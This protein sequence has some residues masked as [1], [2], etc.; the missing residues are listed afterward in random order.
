M[1]GEYVAPSHARVTVGELGPAWLDRQRG[2]LKPSAYRPLEIA[3]RVRVAPR[4]GDVALGDI[5]PTAVQQWVS[6]L[7]RGVDGAKPV[8]ATVVIRTHQVLSAIL[9][10][11]VRDDLLAPN[12]ALASSCP[13]R[14][15]SGHV[16]L[17]HQQVPAGRR[18][19]A[20]TR[21]WCCCWPTPGCDG[22]RRPG[23]GSAISTCCA[24][25]PPSPRTPSRSGRRCSSAPP[26]ATSSAPCRCPSS[27]CPTWPASAR[28]GAATICCSPATTAGICNARTPVGV[29][30]QS[31]RRVRRSAHHAARPSSHRGQPR[32]VG[33]RERQGGPEDARACLGGD[34]AGHLRRPVR[35]RPGGGRDRSARRPRSGKCG[36][37]VGT[38]WRPGS[39]I[40]R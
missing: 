36:Q 30:R 31:G 26:R 24:G 39:A 20:S 9:A 1:R 11:A 28:A 15:A 38:G 10:D 17:T 2:H 13:A 22:A 40:G 27:C 16:Y 6:D 34:D 18:R 5:R 19:R 23:C 32:G 35:R 14:P 33:R 3:W 4:W 21:G 8:G 29:V 25:G 7:G 37:N 12:P